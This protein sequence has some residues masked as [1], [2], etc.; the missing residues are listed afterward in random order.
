MR[1]RVRRSDLQVIVPTTS[2]SSDETTASTTPRNNSLGA[3]SISSSEK[4]IPKLYEEKTRNLRLFTFKELRFATYDF[5]RLLK[6]GGGFGSVYKGFI[7]NW[8][9]TEEVVAIKRF[10]PH[11]L[12]VLHLY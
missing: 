5:S 8:D 3:G 7:K 11:G 4:N 10:N 12:Q 9:G 2:L 1:S 6:I